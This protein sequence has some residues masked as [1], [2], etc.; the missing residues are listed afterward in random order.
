VAPL[1]ASGPALA[2]A[3][4]ALGELLALGEAAGVGEGVGTHSGSA[5][6]SH[7]PRY[8]SPDLEPD[9]GVAAGALPVL[10]AV[11]PTAS[12]RSVTCARAERTKP[13]ATRKL[14]RCTTDAALPLP[15]PSCSGT[16][17]LQSRLPAVSS[18]RLA[19]RTAAEPYAGTSS[20]VKGAAD[21]RAAPCACEKAKGA[22]AADCG[23]H[24]SPLLLLLLPAV[25]DTVPPLL[26]PPATMASPTT[27]LPASA[28]VS[29]Q[30]TTA[31]DAT[32][33][34]PTS[35]SP[36]MPATG[37]PSDASSGT[38]L[39]I[40][41]AYSPIGS[42]SSSSRVGCTALP[43]PPAPLPAPP[44][45]CRVAE[46]APQLSAH[47]GTAPPWLR[48]T[49]REAL[50]TS[51]AAPPAPP[52]GGC[53][54]GC[55]GSAV[56]VMDALDV[57]E[58][59][60]ALALAL[61]GVSEATA[62]ATALLA[63]EAAAAALLPAAF[64]LALALPAPALLPALTLAVGVLAAERAAT[65]DSDAEAEASAGM[66]VNSAL[67]GR[68]DP[69]TETAPGCGDAAAGEGDAAAGRG[70][71]DADAAREGVAV[72]AAEAAADDAALPLPEGDG[73]MDCVALTLALGA[74]VDVTERVDVPDSLPEGVFVGEADPAIER[75]TLALAAAVFVTLC[76]EAAVSLPLAL[77]V[78]VLEPEPVAVMLWLA[79]SDRLTV[80]VML[81]VGATLL[82]IVPLTLIVAVPEL[83]TPGVRLPVIEPVM[84][85]VCVPV[86]D[87]VGVCVDETLDD[88]RGRVREQKGQKGWQE[89]TQGRIRAKEHDQG[90]RVRSGWQVAGTRE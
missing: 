46:A 67:A 5:C 36:S 88:C 44:G 24:A 34:P 87:S 58:A 73:C 64:A 16:L 80:A 42:G 15:L 62:D 57:G 7:R 20:T 82:V 13:A 17:T 1:P 32:L 60:E 81:A 19:L 11:L 27:P 22:E 65:A 63:S 59:G 69:D 14:P 39:V 50:S 6:A 71:P 90:R 41:S 23:T 55:V 3:V 30:R 29:E 40:T 79:G 2:P 66:I 68:G 72:T 38:E 75:L 9:P 47:S 78:L 43:A 70:D 86:P 35:A 28:P 26:P 76:V 48:R 83:D 74:S 52:L 51:P 18:G 25:A 12:A 49:E 10:P 54:A 33:A 37:S 4:P 85:A 53:A 89:A 84:E 77:P 31:P 61:A 8:A 21:A 45:C 56:L